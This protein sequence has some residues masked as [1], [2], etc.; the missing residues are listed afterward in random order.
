MSVST[1]GGV[2]SQDFKAS[3][4]YTVSLRTAGVSCKPCPNTTTTTSTSTSTTTTNI[5]NK[6]YHL[7]NLLF[8]I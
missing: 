3:L 8:G 2:E 7:I 4:S 6:H 1:F 5:N